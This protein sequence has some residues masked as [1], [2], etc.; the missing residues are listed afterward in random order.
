[1]LLGA[2]KNKQ[3]R[4]GSGLALRH[5]TAI[6]CPIARPLR[7]E[8]PGA[9]YHVTSRGNG[10]ADI[11]LDKN[12]RRTFLDVL[13][14]VCSRM[15]GVCYAYCLMTNHSHLVVETPAGNLSQGMRHTA[16]RSFRPVASAP[17]PYARRTLATV[18]LPVGNKFINGRQEHR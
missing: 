5:C 15:Q 12:D 13:G 1:M 3:G 18:D 17:S 9:L 10:R 7:I 4:R 8:F 2:S 11:Y 6:L 14:E 16:M